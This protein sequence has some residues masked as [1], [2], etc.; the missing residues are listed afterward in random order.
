MASPRLLIPLNPKTLVARGQEQAS[1]WKVVSRESQRLQGFF[2][3]DLW[4]TDGVMMVELLER[5]LS[6]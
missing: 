3:H 5:K 4:R 6:S 1:E 2:G